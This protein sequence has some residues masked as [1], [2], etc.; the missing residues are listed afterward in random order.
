MEQINTDTQLLQPWHKPEVMEVEIE[1]TY[2][3]SGP[4]SDG[5]GLT[6]N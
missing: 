4:I 1:E 2:K 6:S 3:S 5:G